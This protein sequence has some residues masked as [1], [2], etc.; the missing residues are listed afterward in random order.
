[1]R[2]MGETKRTIDLVSKLKM[3]VM[4]YCKLFSVISPVLNFS[5]GCGKHALTTGPISMTT[6]ERSTT[7]AG[8]Y[9]PM[10]T[11]PFSIGSI[12]VRILGVTRYFVSN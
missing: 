10:N 4:F 9:T 7:D 8:G 6:M 11:N 1:M 2:R 3:I 12:R 5:W